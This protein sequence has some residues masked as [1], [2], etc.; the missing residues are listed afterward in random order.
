M[1]F[2]GVEMSVGEQG[3]VVG[4]EGILVEIGKD[5]DMILH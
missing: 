2:W 4:R 5:L 1:R 3:L